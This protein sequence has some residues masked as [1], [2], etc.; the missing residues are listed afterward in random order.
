MASERVCYGVRV[1]GRVQGVG[2]RYSVMRRAQHLGVAG[3]VRN[4][5]DGTVSVQCE[6]APDDIKDFLDYLKTGPPGAR[7]TDIDV[8]KSAPEGRR[9]FTIR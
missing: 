3:W 2:F 9:E 8:K 5:P 6:G 4:E 7:V 1:H